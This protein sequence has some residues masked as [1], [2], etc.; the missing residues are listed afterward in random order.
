MAFCHG[1]AVHR[2]SVTDKALKARLAKRPK[3][4]FATRFDSDFAHAYARQ[5]FLEV[6]RTEMRSRS[7]EGATIFARLELGTAVGNGLTQEGTRIVG[8]TTV[9]FKF[10][11]HRGAWRELTGFPDASGKPTRTSLWKGVA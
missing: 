1:D 8:V 9:W 11:Y 2:W 10:Q 5:A 7:T 6:F 3:L 4:Q